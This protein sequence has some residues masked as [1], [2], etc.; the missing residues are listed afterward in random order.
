[1]P[2]DL[3]ETKPKDNPNNPRPYEILTPYLGP[4]MYLY[5]M[6]RTHGLYLPED[7]AHK[8]RT[9][10]VSNVVASTGAILLGEMARRAFDALFR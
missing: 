3:P 9:L 2:T 6:A 7:I 5:R 8:A 10:G 4:C 1:M